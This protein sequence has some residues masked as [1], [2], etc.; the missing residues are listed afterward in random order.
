[1]AAPQVLKGTTM[2][3]KSIWFWVLLATALLLLIV[4]K[5]HF[6]RPPRVETIRV[7]PGLNASALTSIEVRPRGQVEIRALRTNQTWVLTSPVSYPAQAFGIDS[8]LQALEALSP[9]TYITPDE[10]KGRP[11]SGDDYGFKN[12]L[13]TITVGEDYRS[14]MILVGAPTT[15]GD[16]V[17]LQVVGDQG[18]HVVD[19]ELLKFIPDDASRWRDRALIRLAGLGFDRLS[20]T[21]WPMAFELRRTSTNGGWRMASPIEAPADSAR[22]DEM[23]QNIDNLIV[24]RFV[25]DD[26]QPDLEAYGLQ[27][28]VL[29]VAFKN[30]TNV[31]AA[32][33]F[34]KT[35]TN[36]S[37]QV[38]AR[39]LGV[40]SIV[41]VPKD[42]LEP[43]RG[44]VNDF[45]ERHLL[46]SSESV[47]SVEIR[48]GETFY[49]QKE[50]NGWRVL[51]QQMSADS[52]FV[53]RLFATLAGMSIVEFTKDVVTPMDLATYG[54]ARPSRKY[55]LKS[56]PAMSTNTTVA[57]LDFGTNLNDKV[58]VRRLEEASVYAVSTNDFARLPFKP[59]QFRPGVI[60]D[61]PEDQLAGVT[62]R[63]GGRVRRL[64]RQAAHQWSLAPGSAGVIND[65]AIEEAVRPLCHLRAQAWVARGE[66]NRAAYGFLEDGH[67]VLLQLKNGET[68]KIDFGAATPSQSSYAAVTLD[69]EVWIF[70]FPAELYRFVTT[71][72]TVPLSSARATEGTGNLAGLT[73]PPGPAASRQ[74]H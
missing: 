51:P 28:A 56:G 72:L 60:W 22:I 2:K 63:H 40:N 53:D 8:L 14:W 23:V 37:N 50:T 20:V 44:S 4:L 24:E 71:Y 74:P 5:Q 12:P 39:R 34:G 9:A 68:R 55:I 62:L 31:V 21:N 67:Q 54:L 7:L 46:L 36:G 58:F 15:P 61:F 13:A 1:M 41:T 18:V 38:Y 69:G 17:F 52:G 35:L 26:P 30:G 49:L 10:L 27:P 42:L 25:S 19:A 33:Q 73:E 32:L 66:Q 45:R 64:T 3:A 29:Q 48:A 11:N 57:E 59:L 65:L 47:N 16:Q 70:E 43:W 6:S